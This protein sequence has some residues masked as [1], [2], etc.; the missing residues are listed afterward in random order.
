MIKTKKQNRVQIEEEEVKYLRRYF[1]VLFGI[2]IVGMC[3]LGFLGIYYKAL[4][5]S[6]E[7]ARKATVDLVLFAGE[8]VAY[9]TEKL[10]M[11]TDDFGDEFIR[12]KTEE[13]LAKK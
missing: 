7:S 10:N 1:K 3:L 6:A 13:L 12:Y 4:Y 8:E 11:S 9:C 2:T 5:I